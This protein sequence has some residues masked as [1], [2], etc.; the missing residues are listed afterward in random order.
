MVRA[1]HEAGRG[2]AERLAA[3]VAA[4]TAQSNVLDREINRL[5]RDAKRDRFEEASRS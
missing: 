1:I 3:E 5:N 4:L 2:E